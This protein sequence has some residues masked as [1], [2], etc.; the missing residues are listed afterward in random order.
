MLAF[1][2][3]SENFF[4][5][6]NNPFCF[7]T[8]WDTFRSYSMVCKGFSQ[9]WIWVFFRATWKIGHGKRRLHVVQIILFVCFFFVFVWIKPVNTRKIL[10]FLKEEKKGRKQ[11][12]HIY[13]YTYSVFKVKFLF[14]RRKE[15]EKKK[16]TET[17]KHLEFM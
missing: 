8:V 17:S 3:I 9:P 11:N 4:S 15:G 14:S 6:I 16:R 12:L 7:F 2:G 10:F 5:L 13:T 1:K